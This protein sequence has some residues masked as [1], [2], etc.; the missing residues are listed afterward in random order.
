MTT[1]ASNARIFGSDLDAIWLAP[2]GTPLPTGISDTLN[3]A[4]EDVGWLHT[5]GVTEAFGGSK[6]KIR[7][8]QGGAVVRGRIEEGSTEYSF[9][10][11][12][13]KAQTQALRY[14]EK[15][16]TTSGGVRKATRGPGQKVQ[17]RA[18]VIEFYDADNTTLKERLV[19]PRFEIV[20]DGDRVFVNNDIAAFPFRGEVIGNYDTYSNTPTVQTVWTLTVSGT[21]T[22]GSYTL[23]VNGYATAPIAYNANAAAIDAALDALVGVTGVTVTATGSGPFTLTF[24]SAVGLTATSALTGGTSPTATVA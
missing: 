13:S 19:I 16:V 12:E 3:G 8:H 11:L 9:V 18:A 2:L 15:T 22:G 17:L 4:F 21:P 14:D 6:T 23:I 20:P 1:N 10:A 24:S 5:D 7:G